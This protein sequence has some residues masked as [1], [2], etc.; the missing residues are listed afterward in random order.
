MI[1]LA[2]FDCDGTLVD[3]GAPIQAAM[4]AA[5]AELDLTPPAWT[6]TRALVGLSLI[7]VMTRLAPGQT[8]PRHHDLAEAYKRAFAAARHAGQVE[9]PL[10]PGI[11]EALAAFDD[12]GWLLAVATGKS[13]RGLRL[14]LQQHG[15]AGRFVS[16]QTASRHA[17]KPDPSML[18]AAL[19]D[20]GAEAH[21]A[22][23]IGDSSFDMQMARAA[24][25]RAI[26]V[27]WGYQPEARLRA[28]GADAIVTSP[29][30][31]L[32]ACA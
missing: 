15:L 27:T 26:G 9:E 25:V 4:E 1:R 28:T 22:V 13:D 2:V 12:A 29:S 19:A 17:S 14:C 7:E 24:G 8:A 16:L 30:G 20:A 5:F 21:N 23:M 18:F 11:A 6:E 31:L 3:S 32:A 10:F